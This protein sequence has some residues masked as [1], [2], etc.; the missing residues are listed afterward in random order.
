MLVDAL[1]SIPPAIF[2]VDKVTGAGVGRCFAL[3]T[4]SKYWI[5]RTRDL[6][7]RVLP[8]FIKVFNYILRF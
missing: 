6:G 5:K 7:F 4:A 8:D 1:L 3:D 2:M